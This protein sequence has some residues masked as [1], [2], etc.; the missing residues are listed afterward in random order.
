MVK[1]LNGSIYDGELRNN[2]RHGQGIQIWSTGDQ[3]EGQ[4]GTSGNGAPSNPV[5]PVAMRAA[6]TV[7]HSAVDNGGSVSSLHSSS[8]NDY[9][10]ITVKNILNFSSSAYGY[11]LAD[12]SIDAEL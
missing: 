11:Y 9:G 4:F 6:G 10:L 12:L 8:I 7:T 1:W 3:Y 5:L 2:L